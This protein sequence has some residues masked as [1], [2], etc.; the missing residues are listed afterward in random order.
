M[1]KTPYIATERYDANYVKMILDKNWRP[2]E[3]IK[4]VDVIDEFFK[5]KSV[6]DFGAAEGLYLQRFRDRGR[7]VFGVE[8]TEHW[9]GPMSQR[10][11][12]ENCLIHDMRTRLALKR[13]FSLAISVEMLEHLECE[14]ALAAVKNICRHTDTA[15][16]TASPHKGGFYHE[17]PQPK[18]F[19]I[20]KFKKCNFL[21]DSDD[22]G[23]LINMF[24]SVGSNL[25]WL[26][27]DLMIFRR[28]VV[29]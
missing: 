27:E 12:S 6:I 3:I 1:A 4:A 8:G 9:L 22:S 10:I 13:K 24:K 7:R 2:P 19:W 26:L 17:N 18:D 5:P 29:S 15:L 11:G 25:R 14:F 16:I 20:D 28:G 21:F 23:C